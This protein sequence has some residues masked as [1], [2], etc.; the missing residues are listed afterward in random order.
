LNHTVRGIGLSH[1]SLHNERSAAKVT[2][3][4]GNLLA[5]LFG[6]ATMYRYIGAALS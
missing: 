6:P 4:T 1:V 2:D 5:L 3:P